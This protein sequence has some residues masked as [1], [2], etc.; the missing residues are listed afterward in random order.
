MRKFCLLALLCPLLG[1]TQIHQPSNRILTGTIYQTTNGTPIYLVSL[2]LKKTGKKTRSDENGFFSLGN[3]TGSDTLIATHMGYQLLQITLDENTTFPL[4]LFMEPMVQNLEEVIVNTGYQTTPK[5][6]AT[7]SFVKIDNQLLERRVGSNILDRLDGIAGSLLFNRNR[8]PS[9]NE[10]PIMIRGRST[11]FASTEPLIILDNFPYD[12]DISTINPNDIE[13]ITIL[14]DASAASIWGVRA[15]NGVIVITTKKGTQSA[16]PVFRFNMNSTFNERPNLRYQPVT[17]A[18]EYMGLETFLFDRGHYNGRINTPHLS[19]SPL[20]TMLAQ[21]R[22]GIITAADSLQLVNN[23]IQQDYRKDLNDHFYRPSMNQQYTL[24]MDGRHNLG[25]YHWAIGYDKNQGDLIGNQNERFTLRT[26]QHWQILPSKLESTTDLTLTNTR[27]ITYNDITLTSY[28]IYTDLVDPQGTGLP[29]YRDYRSQWLDTIAQR[30]LLDWTY[31]PLDDRD[32]VSNRSMLTDLRLLQT[33]NYTFKKGWGLSLSYQWQQGNQHG[34][35]HRSRQSYFT[36]DLINRFTVP[37]YITGVPTR[38]IPIGGIMDR[39]ITQYYSHNLR[40]Q[41]NYTTTIAEKHS[42]TAV[43]GAEVRDYHNSNTSFRRYGYNEEN[44][45]DIPVNSV[46]Q[47]P[48]LPIGNPGSI[49]T[50]NTQRKLTDR[51]VSYFLNAGY[52]LNQRYLVNLSIRKDESNIFGVNANQR[53]VPLWS[54]GLGWNLHKESFIQKLKWVNQLKL[55][56]TYGFNGNL[57]KSTTAFTTAGIGLGSVFA[58]PASFIINPPNPNL[59]WERIGMWNTAVDFALWNQRI[60]GSIEYYI[61]SGKD[62]IGNSPV[63]TQTGV[64]QFR[65][66]IANLE[67]KGWDLNL[68]IQAMRKKW[69][70]DIHLLYSHSQDIVTKYLVTPQ[71]AKSYLSSMPLN[72]LQGKPWS[73]VFAYPWAG[74]SNNN[75]DPLGIIQGQPSNNYSALVT[76][77]SFADLKYFGSGRP[78]S[79]GS[80]RNDLSWGRF[81]FSF[82]IVYEWGFYFRRSSVAYNTH[83]SSMIQYGNLV[84]GDYMMRWQ[85][86]GD[87]KNTQVPSRVYPA[88]PA[89]DEFYQYAEVLVENGNHI[90]LRDTRLSYDL[91]VHK[92]QNKIIKRAQLYGYINNIGIIWRANQQGIDPNHVTGN[93][94]PRSYALGINVDF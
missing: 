17:D 56:T 57:D 33:F 39:S 90:R 70:W 81:A 92:W 25:Q 11:L 6:R 8:N 51:F 18:R 37:N 41:M 12:A 82:N 87:E 14:R 32:H 29:V 26:R 2:T 46:S 52:V 10:S 22:A 5:E 20:I 31:R 91:P 86:P 79:F 67:T 3:F 71:Q 55:R 19:L 94:T 65:Q 73:A 89:R 66:N 50:G 48:T 16:K 34:H 21:R 78:T 61:K 43:A 47:L 35:Q 38:Q 88:V 54:M 30:Q 45:T 28:P 59:S 64:A 60:S 75:G 36:R 24:S 27:T 42:I 62:L 15:G 58:Q 77:A 74:L 76:P 93:P 1:W 72:P 4:R 68:H 80:I 83:Y 85:K 69:R 13:D 44:Q 63:P 84:H 49:A 23:L 40:L 53:G 7:G 9:V